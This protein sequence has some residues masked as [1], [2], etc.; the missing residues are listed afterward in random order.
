M[1]AFRALLKRDLLNTIRNPML[2]KSR[3]AMT[4]LLSVYVSGLF[5][6]IGGGYSEVNAWRSI[7]G[8]LFFISIHSFMD[9][10]VPV[11]LIFPL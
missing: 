9:S 11:T 5:Y 2:I 3:L 4:I 6:Q 8:F 1:T 7:S 10:L